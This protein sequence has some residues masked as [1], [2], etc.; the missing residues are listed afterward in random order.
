MPAAALVA[1]SIGSSLLGAFGAKSAAGQQ[2]D[3]AKQA[4]AVEQ[5]NQGKA[6]DFQTGIW[7]QDQSNQQPFLNAGTNSLQTLSGLLNSPGQGLLQN[8]GQF[9]APTLEQAQQTP[10]YQFQLQQGTNAINQ[11]AAA[12]GTLL[13]GNTG[14][15]LTDYGQGLASTSY[16]N[17]YN[18]ALQGYMTNFNTFNSNQNNQFNRLSSVAGM[19]QQAAN[20]LGQE[21]QSAASNLSNVYLQGAQ[22]QAQQYGNIGAANA[23]GTVGLFNSLGNV[24]SS[25]GQF[26]MLQQLF[27]HT[28]PMTTGV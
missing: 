17:L 8:Y 28:T 6:A 12:N 5:Q 14:K 13:S 20:S 3:A 7:N 10:G 24:A 27:Q 16:S 19:G 2:S 25:V 21:G 15:A 26:P 4:L 11:N 9:N 18:Q 22:Q 23:S 1:G